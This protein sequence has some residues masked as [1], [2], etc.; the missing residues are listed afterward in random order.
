MSDLCFQSEWGAAS[1]L[2]HSLFGSHIW[3]K[4]HNTWQQQHQFLS[5]GFK[6]PNSHFTTTTGDWLT[7]CSTGW[8]ASLAPLV[9]LTL[10]MCC[11]ATGDDSLSLSL[12]PRSLSRGNCLLPFFLSCPEG[13]EIPFYKGFWEE[14][15]IN[16]GGRDTEPSSF[17]SY[18]FSLF[19]SYPSNQV[20][21]MKL[22]DPFF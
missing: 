22:N 8:L 17:F 1:S 11:R 3:K 16:T 21:P 18:F 6:S 13:N 12:S 15:K 7:K 10:P 14:R 5:S 9:P 2:A 19:L 4:N 20:W